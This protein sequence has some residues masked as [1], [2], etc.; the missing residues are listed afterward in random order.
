MPRGGW[1]SPCA[2]RRW[3][4]QRN[5]I[6]PLR[7]KFPINTGVT[8][9][10]GRTA[11]ERISPLLLALPIAVMVFAQQPLWDHV[12]DDAYISFRYVARWV[13]GQGLT[14]NPGERIEGFSN[15][16]WIFLLRREIVH[17]PDGEPLVESQPEPRPLHAVP[18]Y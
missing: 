7:P 8:A 10:Q 4:G 16:L 6:W 5:Q 13:A 1:R 11:R 12:S 18:V 17:G 9:D 15:P 14:F 3:F 2:E